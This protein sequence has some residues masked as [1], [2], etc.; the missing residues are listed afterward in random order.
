M[1]KEDF[2]KCCQSKKDCNGVISAF[3]L[4]YATNCQSVYRP[5]K[6]KASKFCL[7]VCNKGASVWAEF[8]EEDWPLM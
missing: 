7:K 4:F 1:E 6:Y 2:G 8:W 3:R 5:K